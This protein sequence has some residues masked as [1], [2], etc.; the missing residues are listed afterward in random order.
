M[1]Y[2]GLSD[3]TKVERPATAVKIRTVTSSLNVK[4]KVITKQISQVMAK[5]QEINAQITAIE[6]ELENEMKKAKTDL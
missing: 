6:T 1:Q 3:Y 4:K 2:G 5:N